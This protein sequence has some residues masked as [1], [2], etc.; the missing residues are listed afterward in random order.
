VTIDHDAEELHISIAWDATQVDP[1]S[2]SLT[3]RAERDGGLLLS[4]QIRISDLPSDENAVPDPEPRT[5]A[6]H[7]KL[8]GVHLP[9]GPRNSDWGLALIGPDG[10]LL[11]ERPVARRVERVEVSLGIKDA[12]GPFSEFT[13]GDRKPA[14][15][16]AE[17]DEAVAMVAALE[18]DSQREAAE[19]RITSGAELA[20]YLRWRFSCRAGE[21]LILDPYIFKSNQANLR[22]FL[23]SFNRQI[24]VL[25]GEIKAPATRLLA[26][27]PWLEARS[28]PK[29]LDELHD[30]VWIVGGTA[31]L[32]G[33]SV[34]ALMP[35]KDND[36]TQRT[37]SASELPAGDS[38]FWRER[39]ESWWAEAGA[40]V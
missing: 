3:V 16:R 21:L 8:L 40:K 34:R 32:V 11:D 27:A 9:R 2:C 36:K 30:R 37:T 22:D 6:W 28:L 13:V 1:L 19:R 24:R 14:P 5:R 18:Q 17:S 4:R 7:E 26:R 20:T 38:A 15:T 23:R 31:L 33:N 35:Y 25:T 10:A 29:G 39:F 12:P